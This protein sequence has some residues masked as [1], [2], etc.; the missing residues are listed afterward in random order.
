MGVKG[1]RPGCRRGAVGWVRRGRRG[2]EENR[3]RAVDSGP[4][5]AAEREG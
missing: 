5:G 4:P 2:C 1:V 3:S